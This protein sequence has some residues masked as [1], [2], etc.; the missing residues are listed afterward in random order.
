MA[1]N[2]DNDPDLLLSTEFLGKGFTN[3]RNDPSIH[4]GVD[5]VVKTH[6]FHEDF[7]GRDEIH[8]YNLEHA[9][10]E[11]ESAEVDPWVEKCRKIYGKYVRVSKM[12]AGVVRDAIFKGV[13]L[14]DVYRLIAKRFLFEAEAL[15]VSKNAKRAKG[16]AKAVGKSIRRLSKK[17]KSVKKESSK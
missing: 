7:Y 2:H 15:E 9:D 6:L 3:R 12:A 5:R 8:Q 14:C 1:F 16:K 11:Y 4:R 13:D 17:K 10:D